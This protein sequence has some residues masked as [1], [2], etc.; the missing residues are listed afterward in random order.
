MTDEPKKSG[1]DPL[2]DLRRY[3]VVLFLFL[4]AFV[5]I[6]DPLARLFKDA[7]FR[8]DPVVFG[9]VYGTT[10]RSSASRAPRSSWGGTSDRTR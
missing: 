9:L 8:V 2:S 3:A 6:L 10:L 1:P 7:A 4:S 5:T